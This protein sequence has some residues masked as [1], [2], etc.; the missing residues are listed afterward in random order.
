MLAGFIG[1]DADDRLLH[2][3][4]SIVT[5]DGGGYLD[6]PEY[7]FHIDAMVFDGWPTTYLKC[8]IRPDSKKHLVV[9]DKKVGDMVV[10]CPE[11]EFFPKEF[12][13]GFDLDSEDCDLITENGL[14]VYMDFTGSFITGHA[15]R[16]PLKYGKNLFRIS[17]NGSVRRVALG[18]LRPGYIFGFK[19]VMCFTTNG[20]A[21]LSNV[22]PQKANMTLSL[23]ERIARKFQT[24]VTRK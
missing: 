7:Y 6:L 13:I 16:P 14:R 17:N 3:A 12:C 11:A 2:K 24:F 4:C 1:V 15:F 22:V 9:T 18:A 5:G 21:N 19:N 10:L 23:L 8:Q 20:T